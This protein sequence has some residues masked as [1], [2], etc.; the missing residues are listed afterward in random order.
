V[1]KFV[2]IPRKW[3]KNALVPYGV[4]NDQ[5]AVIL[6]TSFLFHEMFGDGSANSS[7][8]EAISNTKSPF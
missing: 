8:V 2:E 1:T 7:A 4:E 3:Y 6:I 5:L